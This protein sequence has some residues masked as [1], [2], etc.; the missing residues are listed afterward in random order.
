MSDHR[1]PHRPQDPVRRGDAFRPGALRA[2]IVGTWS[3]ARRRGR[4]IRRP[5][6]S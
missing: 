4:R 6:E 5:R 2:A 1:R 3:R